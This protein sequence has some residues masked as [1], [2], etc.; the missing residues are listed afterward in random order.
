MITNKKY[1]WILIIGGVVGI[2]MSFLLTMDKIELLKNPQA[3]LPCNINPIVS[4]GPVI[5]TPQASAFGFP[6]PILGLAGFSALFTV[7]ILL[8]LNIATIENK[9]LLNLLLWGSTFAIIFIH[10]LIVQSLFVVGAL[11]VY[12]M[13]TWVFTWPVFF[14]TLNQKYALRNSLTY[15]I[16]W[17]LL[18]I[19]LILFRFREFFFS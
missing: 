9:K 19:F 2:L 7:G 14:H 12:C 17:Y 11:C 8:L 15:F 3:E 4:C 10:Y 6:N 5:N 1:S 18:I 16:G 13:I